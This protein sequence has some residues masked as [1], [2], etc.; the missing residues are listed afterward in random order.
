MNALG[1]D[2]IL[3]RVRVEGVAELFQP[4]ALVATAA[5]P[6]ITVARATTG[7]ALV[8]APYTAIAGLDGT[9]FA[10]AASCLAYLVRTLAQRPAG[11]AVETPIAATDLGGQRLVRPLGDGS[12]AY[13][14]CDDP[15]GAAATLGLTLGAA[16]AGALV[17]VVTRGPVEEP[18]WAF[19][20]GPAFLGID[21]TITQ[22]PPSGGLLLPIGRFVTPTR[23]VLAIGPAVLLA[24]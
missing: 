22:V 11:D 23:L 16:A 4:R 21:G 5:G 20:P 1:F 7:E 10:D 24:P 13:A 18:S 2:A 17:D 9:T 3:A 12:V 15:D 19:E 6:M 8:C 14:S